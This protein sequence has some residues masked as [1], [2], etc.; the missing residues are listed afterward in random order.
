[1]SFDFSTAK[2]I[3]P[4]EQKGTSFDFS[5]ATHIPKALQ[6]PTT[7]AL[8]GDQFKQGLVDLA[9]GVIPDSL[10]N[11]LQGR[12]AIDLDVTV[13]SEQARNITAADRRKAADVLGLDVKNLQPTTVGES[14]VANIARAGADPTSYIGGVGPKLAT[15]VTAF[16][17][18]SFGTT[19]GTAGSMFSG[20]LVRHLG[21]EEGGKVH[22]AASIVGGGFGGG[23]SGTSVLSLAKATGA[24]T[25]TAFQFKDKKAGDVGKAVDE[26]ETFV[27]T[28][29][30]SNFITEALRSDPA[31]GAKV[32][33][34]EAALLEFPELNIGPWVAM[35]ENPVFR[36][37]L[38]YLLTTNPSFYATLKTQI[39]GAES[40][41]QT[42]QEQLFKEGGFQAEKGIFKALE[43]GLQNARSVIS[44]VDKELASL[45]APT[46]PQKVRT[47]EQI[48][49]IVTR[50]VERKKKAVRAEMTPAYNNLFKQAEADNI[51]FSQ[52]SVAHMHT[53]ATSEVKELFGLMP[54]EYRQIINKWKQQPVRDADGKAVKGEDGKVLMEHPTASIRE[55]DS[56]KRSVNEGLRNPN[57][58]GDSR[59]RL[60]NLKK[61]LDGQIAGMGDFG[62]KYKGLDY[63]YWARLGIPLNKDGI[64]D[65]S[66][67]KF[68]DQVAPLLSRP[69]QA[70]EFLGMVGNMGVP[71][72]RASVLAQLGKSAYD[73]ES[74]ELNLIKLEKFRTNPANREII[75][76]SGLA[77]EFSDI[78]TAVRALDEQ[79][80]SAST[81]YIEGSRGHTR[82]FF[83]RMHESG[84]DG[85]MN[86]LLT[87]PAKT[88]SHLDFIKGLDVESQDIITT[89]LKAELASRAINS[90]KGAMSFIKQ[91]Q[92]AFDDVFGKGMYN[93]LK[94]LAD[95]QDIVSELPLEK[96]HL[97][98]K[99]TKLEDFLKR[100]TGVPL[101]QANSLLRDRI[102]SPFQKMFV[103]MNKMNSSRVDA[104]EEQMMIELFT[105]KG[106]LEELRSRADDLKLDINKPEAVRAFATSVNKSFSRGMYMGMQAAEEE[107]KREEGP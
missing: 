31:L 77:N 1:M 56:L 38:N 17:E 23:V 26:G 88:Q 62:K 105:K 45:S 74:G 8:A 51:N 86:D 53:F 66:S 93:D 36:D 10:Q 14:F 32:E 83:G 34:V 92:R 13:G 44:N 96:I 106:V 59:A 90:G 71:V 101:S 100:K 43:K 30:V 89:G 18:S 98:A 104:K 67:K 103:F 107:L 20:D 94:A 73:V 39:A 28:H 58:K 21:A 76:M 65:I 4:D 75:E 61:E 40:V 85:V 91:N 5:T 70:R 47:P 54:K 64:K 57:I 84:I 27:A 3:E 15:P 72:V 52:D 97:A 19:T 102:M 69:Q 33:H 37:N 63:E 49:N 9:L 6:A 2:R 42:R 35:T 95:M 82:Q 50:L 25:K 68:G 11:I 81:Q 41:I 7:T 99:H 29:Q 12:S 79:R 24:A 48:G 60:E 22:Q 55:L 78:S 80:A 87:S 16:L 46:A